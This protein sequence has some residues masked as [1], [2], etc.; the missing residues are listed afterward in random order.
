MTA[1]RELLSPLL[2]HFGF[3]LAFTAFQGVFNHKKEWV[4]EKGYGMLGNLEY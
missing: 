2:N 3:L 4:R 1:T